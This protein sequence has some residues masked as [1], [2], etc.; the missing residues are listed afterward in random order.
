MAQSYGNAESISV[1]MEGPFSGGSSV[2]KAG[3]L[4]ISASGWKGASSP[5]S[6]LVTTGESITANSVIDLHPDVATVA[7]LCNKGIALMAENYGGAVTIHALGVKPDWDITIQF[8]TR[9]V[10]AVVV[11]ISRL[12]GNAVG[13]AANNFLLKTGD[14]MSGTL[15]MND[16]PLTGIR[17]PEKDTDA[18][19]KMYVDRSVDYTLDIALDAALDAEDAANNAAIAANDAA[20]A[21]SNAQKSADAKAS[22][23]PTITVVLPVS[24]WVGSSAPYTQAVQVE[25][26][27]KTDEPHYGLVFSGTTEQKLAQKEAFACVDDLDT[28]ENSVTFTCFTDKPETDLT[29]QM[30]VIR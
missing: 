8:A 3:T 6:Q 28:A 27:L 5:Y 22:R 9:E 14:A 25:G 12:Y 10:V 20:S 17:D 18:T 13:F 19:H 7:K 15:N 11:G 23:L 29:I 26:I 30:E 4:T 21:A 24:N 2:G 1:Q 16:N